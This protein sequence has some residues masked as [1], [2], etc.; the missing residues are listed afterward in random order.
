MVEIVTNFRNISHVF[1]S[2]SF[3][4]RIDKSPIFIL[5]IS[6]CSHHYLA[7]HVIRSQCLSTL[8]SVSHTYSR[9]RS[10]RAVE[11]ELAAPQ[12]LKL[13]LPPRQLLQS[14]P[15]PPKPLLVGPQRYP[16]WLLYY[17]L[18]CTTGNHQTTFKLSHSEIAV[19]TI[20]RI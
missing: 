1:F 20:Y 6:A 3:P 5:P 15:R 11:L 9:Y 7:F 14:H 4:L 10:P 2:L 8:L 19:G 16:L 18:L 17:A 12:K 13:T